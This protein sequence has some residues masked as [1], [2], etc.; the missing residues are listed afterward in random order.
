MHKRNILQGG[1]PI[2]EASHAMIMI[3]GRGGDARGIMDRSQ[4]LN[5]EGFSLLA[6]QATN[7]TWYPYSFRNRKRK[8][9]HG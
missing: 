9:N 8:M 3:H 2:E 7:S 6:P 4:Y 1:L 5:L